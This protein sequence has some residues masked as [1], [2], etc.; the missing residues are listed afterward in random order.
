MAF[1][2]VFHNHFYNA[3]DTPKLSLLRLEDSTYLKTAPQ[4][5]TSTGQQNKPEIY[6]HN[7]KKHMYA[8]RR[9][10]KCN[11]TGNRNDAHGEQKI[12]AAR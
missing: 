1:F 6:N 12:V 2:P 7:T 4:P 5:Y 10:T 3:V 8:R 11:K 9:R